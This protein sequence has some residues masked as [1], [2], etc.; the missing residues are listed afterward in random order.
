MGIRLDWEIEAEKRSYSAGED[1]NL[2]AKRRGARLRLLVILLLFIGMI[3]VAVVLIRDRANEV[4]DEEERQLLDIVDA[5]FAALRLGDWTSY[6][7]LQRSA[8][9]DWLSV[10]RAVFDEY[11]RLK[12]EGTIQLTGQ[13][14]D[15]VIDGQRARVEVEDII[16]GVPYTRVWFYWRWPDDQNNDN[17]PDGWRHGPPDY[18]DFWGDEQTYESE[19]VLIAYR[20][21]DDAFATQLGEDLDTWMQLGCEVLSCAQIPQVTVSVEP[22]DGLTLQWA[23]ANPWQLR[24]PS[25]YLDGA[26]SDMLF[27]PELQL[28]VAV[29]LAERL[30]TQAVLD[31]EPTYP[32]DGY[33]LR[34]AVTSWLVEQFAQVDT[35]TLLIDSL[36]TNYG[37]QSLGQLLGALQPFTYI[38]VLSAV[39]GA[40]LDQSNL[41]W[42]DFLSWRLTVE[43]ELIGQGDYNNFFNLYD[44]RNPETVDLLNLR[45]N[46]G[47]VPE[48]KTVTLVQAVE[49]LP[50]GTPRLVAT[51]E[52]GLEG[53]TRQETTYFHLVDNIWRRAS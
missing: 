7:N 18:A 40:T 17:L 32:V 22:N 21:V 46:Q 43:D 42:R 2:V 14:H 16:D 1:K 33:Y 28:D 4:A 26:R 44:T 36:V 50:D 35:N 39:T 5:E 10:Q 29:L 31:R 38:D 41:D 13:V 23:V 3:G 37:Q 6:A 25:P 52:V 24:F 49:P 11:Q 30:V 12:L 9:P 53:Q 19:R 47:G 45:F 27:S 8:S 15:V 48:P 20:D 51:V 34:Q